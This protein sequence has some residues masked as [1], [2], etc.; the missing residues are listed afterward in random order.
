MLQIIHQVVFG[1]GFDMP[2]D[3]DTTAQRDQGETAEAFR[4]AVV[5]TQDGGQEA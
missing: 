4:Q 2:S 1:V 5:A 3:L